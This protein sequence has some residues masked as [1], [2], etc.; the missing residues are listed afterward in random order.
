VISFSSDNLDNIRPVSLETDLL[1]VSTVEPR[2]EDKSSDDWEPYFYPQGFLKQKE[3]VK[4]QE[5]RL[6]ADV[7]LSYAH[8]ISQLREK[9]RTKARQVELEHAQALG[10]QVQ[11]V[12][13]LAK[14]IAHTQRLVQ[15]DPHAPHPSH[16]VQPT[17]GVLR[18]R[19]KGRRRITYEETVGMNH[20]VR[21]LG[22]S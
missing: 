16:Y 11:T 5:Y 1:I 8:A 12:T 21:I 15:P 13:K 14:K 20:K 3:E 18:R 10:D 4:L 7:L 2:G 19:T 6:D 17:V 22:H 9:I